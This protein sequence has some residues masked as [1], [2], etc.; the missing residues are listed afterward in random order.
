MALVYDDTIP[1]IAVLR[2]VD[3]ACRLYRGKSQRVAYVNFSRRNRAVFARRQSETLLCPVHALREQIRRMRQPK[4]FAAYPRNS[5]QPHLRL[6]APARRNEYAVF[7][8]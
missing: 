5:F 4:S 1:F 6:A 3:I 2:Q 8:P 7:S